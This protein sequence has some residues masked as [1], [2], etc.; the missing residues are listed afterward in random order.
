LFPG[1]FSSLQGASISNKEFRTTEVSRKSKTMF[2]TSIFCPPQA[3]SA[4]LRF[5]FS[6]T[7]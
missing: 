1:F 7:G 3:D 2:F 5:I 4:V 6:K